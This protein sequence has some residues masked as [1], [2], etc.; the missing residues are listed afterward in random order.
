MNAEDAAL[1]AWL[2]ANVKGTPTI[3]EA[4][5]DGYREFT[6]ISMHTGLP[7]VL[8]WEHHAKQRGLSPEDAQKR[9]KAVQ[10]IYTSEDLEL[11][12]QLLLDLRVDYVI[13]GSVERNSYRRL[14]LDKFDSHPE[15]F[16]KVASFGAANL[17]V[18]YFSK[19][20][21]IYQSVER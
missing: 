2:N 3:L 4:H 5:G 20:N 1:I 10:T 8:G 15:L 16:T 18:T 7:V 17:Y 12:R 14:N 11:T 19:Y 13:I 21:P 9:K 6:R